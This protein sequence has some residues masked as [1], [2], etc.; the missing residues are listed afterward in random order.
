MLCDSLDRN[1]FR[2]EWVDV[3]VWLSP[4]AVHLKLWHNVNWLYSHTKLN[5][6]KKKSLCE[7][8]CLKQWESL[9]DYELGLND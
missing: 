4:F 5:G 3:Y 8:V 9:K 2:G 7:C 6:K 1:E